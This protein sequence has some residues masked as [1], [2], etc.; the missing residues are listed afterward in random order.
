MH[1]SKIN[2]KGVGIVKDKE[3]WHDS[4]REKMKVKFSDLFIFI[5]RRCSHVHGFT[6]NLKSQD[7]QHSRS[8]T[9]LPTILWNI[10]PK[11]T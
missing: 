11:N 5:I 7:T 6:D 8:I 1:F 3:L 4:K 2:N 10:M 9:N